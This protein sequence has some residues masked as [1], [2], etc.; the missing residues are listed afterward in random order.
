L[1]ANGLGAGLMDYMVKSQITPDGDYLP[2]FGV[3]ND[4][5]GVYRKFRT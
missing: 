3:E 4:A 5:E 2:P 1:D